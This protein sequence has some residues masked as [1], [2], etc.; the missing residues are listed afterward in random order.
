MSRPRGPRTD[1]ALYAAV[2]CAA[3]AMCSAR[4]ADRTVD[5][6]HARWHPPKP[7]GFERIDQTLVI[8]LE[9]RTDRMSNASAQ[10][11]RMGIAE[12]DVVKAVPHACGALGCALS[13]ALA[14]QKCADSGE[15]HCLVLEDDFELTLDRDAAAAQIDHLLDAVPDGS[16]DVV[17]LSANTIADAKSPHAMLRRVF[18]A[19]TTSGYIVSQRYVPK[20]LGAFVKSANLLSDSGCNKHQFAADMLASALQLFDRWFVFDPKLGRQRESFSDIEQRAVDYR[21]R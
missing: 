6:M 3:A 19:R 9:S 7:S 20:L 2:L 12:F 21:V 15:P 17:L 14:M 10:L 18:S 11:S 4:P 16:W 5:R 13:H 8:N 1:A